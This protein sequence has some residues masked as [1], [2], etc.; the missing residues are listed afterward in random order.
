M[1]SFLLDSFHLRNK[2]GHNTYKNKVTTLEYHVQRIHERIK[3]VRFL[4]L[5]MSQ[6]VRRL[7]ASSFLKFRR[8]KFVAAVVKDQILHTTTNEVTKILNSD[9]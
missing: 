4:I 7:L 8:R 5:E 3:I 9:L 6:N 1:S 2:L